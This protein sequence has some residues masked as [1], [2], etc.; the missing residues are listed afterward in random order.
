HHVV[1]D[2]LAAHRVSGLGAV[3]ADLPVARRDLGLVV[4]D[5][6]VTGGG[7]LL[8]DV[9]V[10]DAADAQRRR[11]ENENRPSNEARSSIDRTAAPHASAPS[12]TEP[13]RE[14][15]RPSYRRVA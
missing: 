11:R 12:D 5:G 7:E 13:K 9:V 4:V 8:A 1:D 10:R 6:D 14:T 2:L 15:P 3:G